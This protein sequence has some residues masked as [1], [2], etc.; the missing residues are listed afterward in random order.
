MV[1]DRLQPKQLERLAIF[2]LGQ[3]VLFPGTK[4]PLHIFEPRYR[5]MA[6]HAIENQAP[7]AMALLDPTADPDDQ[8]RPAVH[9]VAGVGVIESHERLPDGRFLVV[10]Q[11]VARV[12]I[13]EELDVDTL[14]RQ[15]R[16]ERL[17][18]DVADAVAINQKLSTLQNLT[19]SIRLINPRVADFL[20]TTMGSLEDPGGVADAVANVLFLDPADRQ[21][22]LETVDVAARLDEVSARVTEILAM[23]SASDSDVLN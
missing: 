9:P 2:P 16:A 1:D 23:A 4:L 20:A 21:R 3:A 14:F 10:L 8:G 11:G 15:V 22:L 18:D 5:Q 7:I 12:R 19:F 17:E 13:V 6:E